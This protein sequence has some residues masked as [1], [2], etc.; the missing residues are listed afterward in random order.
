MKKIKETGE[1]SYQ[2][3]SRVEHW[4]VHKLKSFIRRKELEPEV[5]VKT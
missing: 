3:G 2:G 4:E 1:V 5:N